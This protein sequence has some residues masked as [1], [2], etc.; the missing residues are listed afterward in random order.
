M[1]AQARLL[2]YGCGSGILAIAASLLGASEVVGVDIDPQAVQATQDNAHRNDVS[3]QAMLPDSLSPGTFDVVVA[4][5]LSN[6]LKVLAPMLSHRVCAG[7]SL[8][9]SGILQRQAQE[10]MDFYADWVDLS[11]YEALD[12]WV[13]LAG[14]RREESP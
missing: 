13:C 6:P 8:V 12:G 1:P 9:L 3:V 4:N 14:Q 5:I 11:V 7:G 10:V 2:D